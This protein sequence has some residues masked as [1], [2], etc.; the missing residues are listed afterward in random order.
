MLILLSYRALWCMRKSSHEISPDL[1]TTRTYRWRGMYI[2]SA[3]CFTRNYFR[4]LV[5]IEITKTIDLKV[6]L[7]KSLHPKLGEHGCLLPNAV[8][9]TPYWVATCTTTSSHQF[10]RII[11][12]SIF[13]FFELI[14]IELIIS[15]VFIRN[16]RVWHWTTLLF[17]PPSSLIFFY[18]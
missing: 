16:L 3:T 13:Q 15:L 18:F 8:L 10:G 14:F 4:R 1:K 7:V 11:V 17:S 6:S 2:K 5:L 12:I 9:Y